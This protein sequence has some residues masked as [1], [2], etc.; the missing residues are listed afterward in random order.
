MRTWGRIPLKL[1]APWSRSMD[2]GNER[3]KGHGQQRNKE[4]TVEERPGRGLV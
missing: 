3:R 2:I 4:V 1:L